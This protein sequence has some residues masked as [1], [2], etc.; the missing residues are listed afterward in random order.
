MRRIDVAMELAETAEKTLATGSALN[1]L[2][3]LSA[4][5]AFLPPE[6]RARMGHLLC[7]AVRGNLNYGDAIKGTMEII[8][9]ARGLQVKGCP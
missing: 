3:L 5:P 6:D 9:S 2:C 4:I 7:E 8:V 1:A